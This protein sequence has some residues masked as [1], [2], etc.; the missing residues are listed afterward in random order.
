MKGSLI[1][2]FLLIHISVLAQDSLYQKKIFVRKA[3]TIAYRILY[4]KNYDPAKSYPL[5]LVLHGAGERGSDNEKQLVH[6]SKLFASEKVRNEFPSIVIFPQ[7]KKDS[8]W[9]SV[10]IDRDKMPLAMTF[11]YTRN[12]TKDLSMAIALTKQI[13]KTEAVD[14]NR[15]YITGLSMG[16]MGTFEAVYRYP[17][18][19]AAA[20][21]ICGG[22]D[23]VHYNKKAAS[24]P[25][26]IFHGESDNVV[27]AEY[28]RIMYKRIQQ[29]SKKAK[30]T[31]YPGVMHNSW[32]NAFAEPEF[33]PWLFAN[34]KK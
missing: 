2:L 32:D 12:E 21:P 18:L 20:A 26:W 24:V 34:T 16:G 30:Y 23:A 29:F 15:V 5:V 33:L 7:C 17:K 11:D 8:Y 10:K 14:K 6:G 19:F 27:A 9:S 3:D 4:P 25:F 22:G 31:E 28:S 13:I 1:S